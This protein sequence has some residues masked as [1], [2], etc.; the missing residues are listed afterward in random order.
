[1]EESRNDSTSM[2]KAMR[3]IRITDLQK[4]LLIDDK[5]GKT[6]DE[7]EQVKII[8][9][10]FRNTFYDVTKTP[11]KHIPPKGMLTPFTQEEIKKATR[12][13]QNNKSTGTARICAELLK[14]SPDGMYSRIAQIFN[15][16][17]RSGE[18]PE[19]LKQGILLPILKSRKPQGQ[20]ANLRPI[21]LLSVIRNIFI[22][23]FVSSN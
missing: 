5:D 13:L 10:Y 7:T 18:Y 9:D 15:N 22:I 8:T 17:A 1:M 19:E 21:I 6:T 20:S 14:Y 16:I 12:S 11:M 4:Q 23:I 2:Y 3:S